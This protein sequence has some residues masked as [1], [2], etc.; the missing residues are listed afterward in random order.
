MTKP[1]EEPSPAPFQPA[2]LKLTIGSL[3]DSSLTIAAH[4]NPRELQID[5]SIPWGN[6]DE[7]DNTKK[8]RPKPGQDSVEFNGA[9]TRTMSIELLFDGFEEKKSIEPLI[10]ALEEMSSAR[11]PES[12]DEEER[13]PHYCVVVWGEDMPSFRC[14]IEGLAV[15][16]SM[17]DTRGKPLRAICTVKLKEARLRSSAAAGSFGKIFK[18]ANT[19]A[20]QR[21]FDLE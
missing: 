10:A 4:Y 3:D 12:D 16:Y 17:F 18:R 13:R 15:K 7:R 11:D 6:H 19:I 5:K 14:V 8:S 9:P 2:Q 20:P 21:A 1:K